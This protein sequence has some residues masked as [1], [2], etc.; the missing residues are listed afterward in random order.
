MSPVIARHRR[1]H[2]AV[3]RADWIDVVHLLHDALSA[4][5]DHMLLVR[6]A[7]RAQLLAAKI[8][9]RK[10]R[11]VPGLALDIAL[12]VMDEVLDARSEQARTEEVMYAISNLAEL[13]DRVA[14]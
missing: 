3:L 11:T 12:R 13:A 2:T 7:E 10:G 8:T 9:A 14:V 5:L 1:S 4:D 6:F